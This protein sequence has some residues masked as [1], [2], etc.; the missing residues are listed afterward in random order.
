MRTFHFYIDDSGTRHPDHKGTGKG[1]FPNWFSLGGVIVEDCEEERLRDTVDAFRTKWKI[2]GPL[3]SFPIRQKSGEFEWLKNDAS[4]SAQFYSELTDL[5]ITAPV[6]G[7]ACV[8]DRP[9][10][11]L[12]YQEQYGRNRWSLCRTAFTITVE[13]AAKYAISQNGRL[14]VF[15][16]RSSKPDEEKLKQY[17][18]E[19][20]GAGNPFNSQ[21]S[22]IYNPLAQDELKKA[23]FEFRV[24][25]KSSPIMQLADLYLYPISR[26]GYEPTYV[27]YQCLCENKKLIDQLLAPEEK[28][29]LGIKYSCFDFP[30][31]QL[32]RYA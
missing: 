4:L 10:Y 32:K 5:L 25:Q 29:T 23:L 15:V 6:I 13:R 30:I 7:H 24:K 8:I 16:E 17:Y 18:D 27:P 19:M 26:G 2:V 21:T 11:N 12:R 31:D 28:P 14:R 20:R 3:H 22:S 9:S 1:D